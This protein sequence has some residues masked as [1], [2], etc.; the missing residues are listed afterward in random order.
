MKGLLERL[1]QSDESLTD[2]KESDLSLAFEVELEAIEDCNRNGE[3]QQADALTRDITDRLKH[4]LKRNT[5]IIK[6]SLQESAQLLGAFCQLN[7]LQ[8]FSISN[9]ET[10]DSNALGSIL[11]QNRGLQKFVLQHC[12]LSGGS[13][14]VA[15]FLA[16]LRY[17]PG[18]EVFDWDDSDYLEE[19]RSRHK[20]L[21]PLLLALCTIPKLKIVEVSAK[22]TESKDRD[23]PSMSLDA[24]AALFQS[25]SLEHLSLLDN[26]GDYSPYDYDRIP[27]LVVWAFP[28]RKNTNLK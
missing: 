3:T 27:D 1:R 10:V 14:A 2:L 24:I 8:E 16:E 6:V 21:V 19:N 26:I 22:S 5:S 15:G 7:K 12:H 20:S 13:S 17:H 23:F 25:C 9:H 18:L 4:A 11:R 28:L